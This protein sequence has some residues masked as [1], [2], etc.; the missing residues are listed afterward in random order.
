[1]RQN[2]GSGA[3]AIA[4]TVVLLAGCTTD[5]GDPQAD[6]TP[7]QSETA[8]VT[9]TPTPSESP[10]P[11]PTPTP[12]QEPLPESADGEIREI[13]DRQWDKIVQTGV[14]RPECPVDRTQLRR[15]E[16]NH[17]TFSGGVERGVLVVNEDIAESIVRIFT[18]LYDEEFPIRQMRPVEEFGGDVKVSLGAD[19]TSAF[20]CRRPDQ[21]NAPVEKSPHAN[22][23]AIDINPLENPWVDL[24]CDC[25]T[26]SP[27]YKAR[28]PGKGKIL[29]NGLVWQ[30]F[31][32]EGWIWQNI[33]VPDYMHF[34]TGYPSEPYEDKQA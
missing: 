24:R 10:T 4:A 29:K 12:T 31:T 2:I 5:T 8:T 9:P 1:M 20:N 25:W 15:V 17:H 23:R 21:I 22:G 30:V 18:R 14:W 28:T 26:P 11:T 34:D 19:N 32:E 7:T 16:I 6:P 13:P 3:V 27:R 33:K